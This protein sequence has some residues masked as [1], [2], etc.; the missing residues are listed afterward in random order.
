M[1]QVHLCSIRK[2]TAPLEPLYLPREAIFI[3]SA[4]ISPP[5]GQN[6]EN[7]LYRGHTHCAEKLVDLEIYFQTEKIELLPA[8]YFQ[9]RKIGFQECIFLDLLNTIH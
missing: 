8:G 6:A 4:S 3:Q 7:R 9:Q 1:T 2:R 5:K